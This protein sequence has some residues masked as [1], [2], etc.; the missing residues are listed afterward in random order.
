MT[1]PT[2]EQVIQ[3]TKDVS[4]SKSTTLDPVLIAFYQRFAAKARE[5]LI[6]E[7]DEAN[8]LIEQLRS[9]VELPL[10]MLCG[11]LFRDLEGGIPA[12]F[13][14]FASKVSSG[15]DE[16]LSIEDAVTKAIEA[17]AAAKQWKEKV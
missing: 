8:K 15:A 7:R 4:L 16:G 5:D 14:E 9:S 6:A 1:A 13:V 17:L 12:L 11:F 10:G 3:W 2:R